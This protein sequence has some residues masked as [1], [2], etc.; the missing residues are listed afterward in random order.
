MSDKSEVKVIASK[1]YKGK[2]GGLEND[3]DVVVEFVFRMP[4]ESTGTIVCERCGKTVEPR[5]Y[6]YNG[7]QCLDY[8][9]VAPC[10]Q[11]CL[12]GLDTWFGD[13]GAPH[14]STETCAACKKMRGK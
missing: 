12:P 14:I 7:R 1:Y 6:E 2:A 4:P 10:G 9:H 11:R 13:I 3:K 8:S 5:P